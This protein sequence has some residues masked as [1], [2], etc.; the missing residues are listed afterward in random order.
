MEKKVGVYICSGCGIG[1][2]MDV[3]KLEAVATSEYKA[4]VC[5]THAA[6]CGEEG[7]GLIRQ[8]LEKEGVNTVVIAACS[9]RAKTDVFQYDPRSV[10][11]ERV[12]IREHVA[13]CQPPQDENTQMMAEDYLRMGVVKAQKMEPPE[14]FQEEI[15]KRI[16][17]VGGGLT[18]M[19]AAKQAAAAG[20]EVVLVE[21]EKQLGGYMATLH[22]TLPKK[23]PYLEME[24]PT[25]AAL[26]Q[27]VEGNDKIKVF[28][29]AR[30]QS[31]AGAPGMFDVTINNG[32]SET[33][34]VGAIV[35]AAGFKRY[36]ANKL[37]H[38]GYGTCKNVVT[39][40]DVEG[41]ARKGSFARPSDGAN[42]RSVAFIQCAGSRDPNHLKYCST[43]C[44]MTSLK[45]AKYIRDANPDAKV[46]ILYRDM[47]TPGQY[48]NYYKQVQQDE[49][50]F[51]TKGDVTSVQEDADQG[52]R[53]GV[54]H[55]LLGENIEIKAD[56]VVLAT[57]MVPVT[58]DEPIVNL[59]YRQGPA[60]RDNDIFDQYA[61]SNYI[62]FPYETQRT[63]IY[64]AGAIRRS[65]TMEESVE[66]ATGAALKA[67]Q[68][69]ESVNRGVAVHP[70]SGDMTFPDFFFQRCTQ[71][72]RCTQECP[73]GAL[74]DDARGTPKPNPT[75]CRRCGTCMGACPERIIGFADYN[76]DSIGSMVKAIGV[77]S[78]DDY[79]EPPMRILGL[80]CE[81]DAL[82]AL[83]IAAL[84]KLSYSADVRFIPVRCLGSV[85]VI[86]IK[87]ALSKGMDGAFWLGCK[88]GDDYQCQ[89]VK[90]SELAGIRMKKIG[91][92]LA[93]LAL[94]VERVAQFEIAIDEYDKLPKMINDFVASIEAMG[95]N[96]FKGF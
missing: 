20:Y 12:N 7:A 82:P 65:M 92:A 47:R 85:N 70:R 48:E 24:V 10:L 78:S 68:C 42:A 96:P 91:E 93:S 31:T 38:L 63:G 19:T 50:I 36:D 29:G 76:I 37:G 53:I 28:K 86:W 74:D 56:L 69:L 8:D 95:P 62:C 6:L 94:E 64:A 4:P 90:G 26:A 9:R 34:R 54:E 57:G 49:G 88:Y 11:L 71:C 46:Y 87:D 67:I 60:F 51:L 52:L 21:K 5:R 66:D 55:T 81:N 89:F 14:P 61:D 23:S 39:H 79:E 2:A 72:K 75:R 33:V 25:I 3:A 1:D 40:D 13:W 84:N 73:F 16:L 44:C 58:A 43:V 35:E 15:S 30:I 80:V 77:P 18:G 83:D 45:Q 59:A 32:S 27:E 22:R 17:V 41:M